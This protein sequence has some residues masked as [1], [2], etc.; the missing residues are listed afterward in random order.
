MPGQETGQGDGQ[1]SEEEKK[2]FWKRK[3]AKLTWVHSLFRVLF[4]QPPPSQAEATTK[5]EARL[6]TGHR[7][8]DAFSAQGVTTFGSQ[9]PGSCCPPPLSSF[10]PGALLLLCPL[11]HW[12]PHPSHFWSLP[13]GLPP[14]LLPLNP[15]PGLELER[16]LGPWF[17]QISHRICEALFSLV[18]IFPTSSLVINHLP[19]TSSALAL[20]SYRLSINMGSCPLPGL[21]A[22]AAVHSHQGSSTCP[23]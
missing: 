22:L 20:L 4:Y 1:S 19:P 2:I 3:G 21:H 14:C 7:V 16:N 12:D 13:A 8:L 10:I 5:M 17:S 15:A 6:G 18:Y 11:Y 23:H 9:R